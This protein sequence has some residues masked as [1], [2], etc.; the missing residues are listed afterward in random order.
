[1]TEKKVIFHAEEMN[2]DMH[3][4]TDWQ[5][6]SWDV[7]NDGFFTL[8]DDQGIYDGKPLIIKTSGQLGKESFDELL[9]FL[10]EE[11]PDASAWSER[12]YD[13][14]GWMFE[15]FD[16]AG[17][18]M[19]KFLGYIYG[20][21]ALNRLAKLLPPSEFL[22]IHRMIQ[23]GGIEKAKELL[24]SRKEADSVQKTKEEVNEQNPKTE[25]KLKMEEESKPRKAKHISDLFGKLFR[26]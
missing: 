9:L 7:Y 22:Q 17:N 13:G 2:W 19:N 16:E 20:S 24:A 6:T 12:A 4:R 26:K 25:E 18:S 1:M 5:K 3:R 21:E 14:T 11:F 10:K 23:A 15:S 8:V